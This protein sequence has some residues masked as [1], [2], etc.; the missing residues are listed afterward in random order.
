[1][2][3]FLKE[4]PSQ[5]GLLDRLHHMLGADHVGVYIV[6]GDRCSDTGHFGELFHSHAPYWRQS[7]KR[8]CS[9]AAAAMAGLTRCVRPPR[10]CRPLKL[11]LEVEAHRSPIPR[12]SGFMPRH[13]EQPASRQSNPAALN[14]VCRP[15][16]SAWRLTSP[17]PGTIIAETPSATLRPSTM[18]A[19]SRRSSIRLLV[20][21][22]I[23]T[24]SIVMSVI[25][26]PSDSPI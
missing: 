8:P 26:C 15:S 4:T 5:A 14:T 1:E 25:F 13:M 7:T 16:A 21:E 9:A 23:K 10:P 11:R 12:R 2:A 6:P 18:R 17:E 19:T 22:P 24:L 20:H 3:V